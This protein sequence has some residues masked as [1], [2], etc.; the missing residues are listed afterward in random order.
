MSSSYLLFLLSGRFFGV[1]LE[2]ALEIL[3][4]R[5]G[6]Q[7]PLAYSYV[8]GLIE[9][10]GKIYPVFNLAQRLGLKPQ[11]AIGFAATG[12]RPQTPQSIILL[13]ER[14]IPFG[15]TVDEILKMTRIDEITPASPQGEEGGDRYIRGLVYD[16]NRE[17]I[18]LDFER[19]FFHGG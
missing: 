1:K 3:P 9:Y 10:R 18:L 4:W 11:E 6:R 5:Q 2:G 16:E 19:L 7:V 14:N 15:I 17:I 13:E 12:P 8:E